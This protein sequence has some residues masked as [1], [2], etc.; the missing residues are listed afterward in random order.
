[1]ED[2][3]PSSLVVRKAE[4]EVVL[5]ILDADVRRDFEIDLAFNF[6]AFF[7]YPAEY[8]GL[9]SLD[10]VAVHKL[11]VPL[12][13]GTSIT[14]MLG[15]N[16][17]LP[18]VART[19]VTIHGTDFTRERVYHEFTEIEGILFP[20]TFEQGWTPGKAQTGVLESAEVNVRFPHAGAWRC[21]GP[22]TRT[23]A[24]RPRPPLSHS[25]LNTSTGSSLDAR[26]AGARLAVPATSKRVAHTPKYTGGSMGS[27]S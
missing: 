16:T 22:R 17:H 21:R 19:E 4:Q 11:L 18:L 12:L 9:D 3:P 2:A 7:D 25:D 6:P 20:S 1:M 8:L 5:S 14:Y 27:T 23:G 15:A 26:T 10:G 24:G 13:L